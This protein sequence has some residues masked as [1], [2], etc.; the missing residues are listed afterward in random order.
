LSGTST[1]STVTLTWSPITGNANIGYTPITTYAIYY[2]GGGAST[3]YTQVLQSNSYT[4]ST[5]TNLN[6][7]TSYSF[8][9]AAL[10]TQGLGPFSS[11]YTISTVNKPSS[12]N[13]PVVS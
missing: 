13:P 2:N 11:I 7:S 10:N 5:I 1:T 12:P 9:I 4:G 6:A 3:T 8:E